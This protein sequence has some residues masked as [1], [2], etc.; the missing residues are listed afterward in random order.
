MYLPEPSDRRFSERVPI[1]TETAVYFRISRDEVEAEMLVENLSM[2][3][4]LL[5]APGICDSLYPGERL[6]DATLIFSDTDTAEVDVIVRWQVW[7][8]VG[9]QFDGLTSDAADQIS[10]LLLESLRP[11]GYSI[12]RKRAV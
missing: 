5:M 3:G 2:S 7:P 11:A 12:Y 8:R 4:A 6:S 10:K 1:S 9:V